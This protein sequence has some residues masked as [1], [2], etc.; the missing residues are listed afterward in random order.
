MTTLSGLTGF[1]VRGRAWH[2]Q[3]MLDA[4]VVTRIVPGTRV[5]NDV[6]QQYTEATTT[7]Y[8]G[9]CRIKIWRGQDEEAAEQEVN[10]QRYYLDLP[11]SG[12]APDVRRRDTVT[13]TAS[14]NAALV[15]R[16][17]ILTNAEAETTDTAF[18][19]TCE[20]AQ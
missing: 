15:G 16:V 6:T 17:L 14:L 20:F 3:V 19:I 2:P 7:V 1:I 5:Y 18:R 4:C 13:I 12:T 10:V 8:T 11:L 9:P